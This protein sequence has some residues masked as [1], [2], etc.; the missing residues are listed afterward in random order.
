MNV[1]LLLD[2]FSPFTVRKPCTLTVLGS[3]KSAPM[4]MAGQN[5]RWKY[6]MSLPMKWM[7]VE[8]FHCSSALPLSPTLL[9]KLA[10]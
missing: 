9:A 6:M 5:R 7:M 10:M 2:I 4:S 3:L 1:P 8:S